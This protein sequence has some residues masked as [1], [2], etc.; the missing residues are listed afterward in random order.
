[1]AGLL[2]TEAF[3]EAKDKNEPLI[4][5][6]L[7]AEKAFDIVWHNGLLRKLYNDGVGGD[8]WL[9]VKSLHTD[10]HTIV[11]WQG[12]YTH[13]IPIKQGI[14]QGAK[15]STLMYKRFNNDIL[16][17]LQDA[18]EG[19]KI[20]STDVTSPTCADD[21]ALLSQKENDA[22]ILTNTVHEAT[23]KDR[24]RINASKCELVNFRTT[25]K[26]LAIP[27][28]KYNSTN[29]EIVSSAKHLGIERNATNTPDVDSRIHLARKTAYALLGSGLHGKNGISPIISFQMWS[30]FV[31]PRL[32]H[33]IELL[34]I[35]KSDIDALERYQ[36]KF[37]KQI[38]TL[39]E[40][41][42][43]VAVLSLLGA[44]T[45]EA[46]IDTRII[47]TFLNIAKDPRTTEFQIAVRQLTIKADNSNSWFIKVKNILHKYD[48]PCPE[49]L[50]KT[51]RS[52][53]QVEA[54]KT[55]SNQKI[56]EYWEKMSEKQIGEKSTLKYLQLQDK[57]NSVPHQV[58][59][60][61][62]HS[63]FASKKQ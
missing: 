57:S 58:W 16:N 59:A 62:K 11:K 21:I 49:F 39:P 29:I 56:A 43:S 9:L 30:T 41:T 14:R 53:K 7:D 46:Q 47:T 36:R 28:V 54:W 61:S 26:Q 31:I 48:L 38:Q 8:L 44:K 45:I 10:A 22:Q 23:K 6:T 51:I 50:L 32:L 5:Q 2:I 52:I 18:P 33:G 40:R 25:T 24:F 63:P 17:Q 19:M 20:G 35:R 60:Y 13:P 12:E 4:M 37:L 3:A 27:T 34:N 42:A 55:K 15:L 1:M